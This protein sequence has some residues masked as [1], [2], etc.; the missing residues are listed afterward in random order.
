MAYEMGSFSKRRQDLPALL[1]PR[2]VLHQIREGLVLPLKKHF[3]PVVFPQLATYSV[4]YI[5]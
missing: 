1:V 4:P 3:A 2:K 5:A